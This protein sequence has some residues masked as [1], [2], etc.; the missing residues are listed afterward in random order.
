MAEH[1]ARV[2]EFSFKYFCQHRPYHRR[3]TRLKPRLRWCIG[4][5]LTI[6]RDNWKLWKFYQGIKGSILFGQN[7]VLWRWD[8][9]DVSRVQVGAMVYGGSALPGQH[10]RFSGPYQQD[11]K[12]YKALYLKPSWLTCRKVISADSQLLS[13]FHTGF[14]FCLDLL[15]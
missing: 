14:S 12:E 10:A 3:V 7:A 5:S 4:L 2:Q 8:W 9:S 1:G 13:K 11:T 6:P 15:P